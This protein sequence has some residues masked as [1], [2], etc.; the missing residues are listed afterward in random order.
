M[1]CLRAKTSLDGHGLQKGSCR[2]ITQIAVCIVS[3]L[4]LTENIVEQYCFFILFLFIYNRGHFQNDTNYYNV[5]VI[6]P[7]N[8]ILL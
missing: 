8:I 5:N 2:S 6:A 4:S 1:L 3:E 7:E